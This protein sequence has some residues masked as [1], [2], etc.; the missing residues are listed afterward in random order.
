[1]IM[2][3]ILAEVSG[4]PPDTM[5]SGNWITTSVVAVISA[6]GIA[7]AR[8]SGK[9]AG[10]AEAQQIGPQPFI[11]KMTEE[12]VTRREFV[13]LKGEIRNDVTEMKN[14]FEK[15]MIKIDGQNTSLTEAIEEGIKEGRMGRVALWNELNPQGKELAA[16]K[17]TGDVAAQIGK[18]ADAIKTNGKN[19][20]GR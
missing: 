19:P 11:V 4:T 8:N 18:L 1:M 14:L 3:Q 13:E 16:L 10:R 17:A 20:P 12:F 9:A 15:T 7:W 6:L 5:I 2:M